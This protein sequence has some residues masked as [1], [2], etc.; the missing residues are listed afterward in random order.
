MSFKQVDITLR[1]NV[2]NILFTRPRLIPPTHTLYTDMD[3]AARPRSNTRNSIDTLV[4]DDNIHTYEEIFGYDT[5]GEDDEE[6]DV[7]ASI[8]MPEGF[9]NEMRYVISNECFERFRQVMRQ[10]RRL[11]MDIFQVELAMKQD[12]LVGR[13]KL[14]TEFQQRLNDSLPGNKVYCYTAPGSKLRF[15]SSVGISDLHLDWKPPG[16]HSNMCY[17]CHQ[18]FTDKIRTLGKCMHSFCEPCVM[19]LE[20]PVIDEC[21]QDTIPVKCPCCR[22]ITKLPLVPPYQEKTFNTM[23]LN[24]QD[25]TLR[26]K[27]PFQ[28]DGCMK[29]FLKDDLHLHMETCLHRKYE[30]GGCKSILFGEQKHLTRRDCIDFLNSTIADKDDLLQQNQQLISDMETQMEVFRRRISEMEATLETAASGAESDSN[31]K[32]KKRSIPN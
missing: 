4:I 24:Y 16:N 8:H 9:I 3:D 29:T 21:S 13:D 26:Y 14:F 10:H 1:A 23:L 11:E 30:C 27:C 6:H 32:R 31:S 7:I 22:Q 28:E 5:G 17:I 18:P 25:A 2:N 12:I 20:R 19:R 15:R